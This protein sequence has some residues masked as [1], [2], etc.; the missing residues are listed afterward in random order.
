MASGHGLCWKRITAR[1]GLLLLLEVCLVLQLLLLLGGHAIGTGHLCV[2]RRHCARW[3]RRNGR[4]G[5]LGGVNGGFTINPVGI[6][7]FRSIEA[8]L[9]GSA[10]VRVNEA[11]RRVV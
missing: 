4:V 2:A 3:W 6:C 7:G 5:V 10:L 9:D 1:L 8:C 11:M